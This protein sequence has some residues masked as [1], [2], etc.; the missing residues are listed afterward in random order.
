FP[1]F[2]L[3]LAR[4]AV[5]D[6]KK[7]CADPA[8]IADLMLYYVEQGVICTNNYGDIDEHFYASVESVFANAITMIVE[9][10][11]SELAKQL[12]P[13]AQGI[14]RNT[15]GIGWGFH[16]ALV[17]EFNSRYPPEKA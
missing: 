12:R 10:G 7:A 6:F 11:D 4:K 1:K 15:S 8:A 17:D 14:I 13:R 9:S 3:R 5:T 2:N 16:D